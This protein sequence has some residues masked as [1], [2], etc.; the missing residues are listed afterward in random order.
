MTNIVVAFS[1]LEDAKSIKNILMRSGFQVVAVCT[2]GSQVLSA[3]ED[4][5]CGV[6][7]C[8]HRFA[9]MMH[10]ELRECLPGSV[11]ILL[12]SS[13]NLWTGQAPKGIVRLPMPLKVQ[14]LLQ[15][16]DVLIQ[17]QARQRRRMRRHPRERNEEEQLQIMSAKTL[18]MEQNHMTESEAHRYLQKCSM[19]S[20][21]NMTETAQMVMRLI[22]NEEK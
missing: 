15:T 10:E 3:C 20:G 11:E 19:N 14:D 6:L 22:K 5:G 4:I 8:G 18:L 7:V 17:T 16:L 21:T 2:S 12:L 13:P 1:R 9:D